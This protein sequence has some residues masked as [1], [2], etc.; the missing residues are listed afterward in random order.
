MK[1][2]NIILFTSLGFGGAIFSLSECFPIF[3]KIAPYFDR[4]VDF[5]ENVVIFDYK[6]PDEAMLY[7]RMLNQG[8]NFTAVSK[9][10]KERDW[11]IGFRAMKD[12][13]A[14]S[15]GL[16]NYEFDKNVTNG[17]VDYSCDGYL[18]KYFS[19]ELNLDC[20]KRGDMKGCLSQQKTYKD[21]TIHMLEEE[22]I[23]F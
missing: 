9:E 7:F 22:L 3:R 12:G 21:R 23:V 5:R 18:D 16:I 4:N 6:I 11:V 8:K 13:I 15:C 20:R 10:V 14:E 17:Y 1:L 19:K 2:K